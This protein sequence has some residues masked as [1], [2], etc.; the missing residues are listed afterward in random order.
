MKN[1]T[2]SI[3]LHT[4]SSPR[5]GE[6]PEVVPPGVIL[7]IGELSPEELKQFEAF[8]DDLLERQAEPKQFLTSAD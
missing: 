1:Q 4:P 3:H 8:I 2:T 7:K 6:L 5:I